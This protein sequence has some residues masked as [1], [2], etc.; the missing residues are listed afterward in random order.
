MKELDSNDVLARSRRDAFLFDFGEGSFREGLD[1]L[2][3]SLNSEADLTRTRR[4][5]VQAMLV[6]TLVQRLQIRDRVK[7]ANTAE[8]TPTV[9]V[10]PATDG[11]PGCEQLLMPTFCSSAFAGWA[12]IP[13]YS[14]WL[15]DCDMT[16]AYE[17][18]RAQAPQ[19]LAF[20]SRRHLSH[21]DQLLAVYPDAVF[22]WGCQLP[23]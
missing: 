5:R 13:S 1:V 2:V 14:R 21:I 16:P 20:D 23:M 11:A 22:S 10:G 8:A 9:V 19:Q 3:E 17:F 15:L 12:H 4:R 18:L 7:K 6:S